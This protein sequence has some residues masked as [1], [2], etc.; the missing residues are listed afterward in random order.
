MRLPTET[1]KINYK[2]YGFW[3]VVIIFL[4]FLIY[5]LTFFSFEKQ[6]EFRRDIQQYT[7]A[8]GVLDVYAGEKLV[9]RFLGI[10]KLTTAKPTFGEVQGARPYRYGFGYY[11][12]NQNLT[13]DSSEKWVYIEISDH[14]T[15]YVF[16]GNPNS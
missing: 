16:Y 6:N 3:S 1:K 15:N 10:D 13:V 14:S 12:K 9:A 11:D 8:N 7:G 4:S 5:G 2:Y